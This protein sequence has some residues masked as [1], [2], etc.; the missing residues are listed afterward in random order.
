[1]LDESEVADIPAEPS[2]VTPVSPPAPAPAPREQPI[3]KAMAAAVLANGDQHRA[4]TR[5]MKR[6]GL[7]PDGWGECMDRLGAQF[8]GNH[9]DHET[10]Y[11]QLTAEQCEWLTRTLNADTEVPV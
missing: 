5:A 8:P 2:R 4:L 11:D 9:I 10:S 1:M 7:Y 3:E 6:A